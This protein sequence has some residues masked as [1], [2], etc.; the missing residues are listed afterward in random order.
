MR[1]PKESLSFAEKLSSAVSVDRDF[2][3]CFVDKSV[4]TL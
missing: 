2:S 3:G 4:E 1:R